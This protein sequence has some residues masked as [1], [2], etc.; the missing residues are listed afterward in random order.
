MNGGTFANTVFVM[1][2]LAA[3]VI[4]FFKCQDHEDEITVDPSIFEKYKH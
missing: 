4:G 2:T 1:L 3:F